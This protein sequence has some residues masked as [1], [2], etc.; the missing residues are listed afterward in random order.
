MSSISKALRAKV[1]KQ[2]KNQC[3]YCRCFQKYILT[4]LEIDHII[5]KASGGS[6]EEEN[7]WLACRSCNGYKGVQTDATDPVSK[8]KCNL[9]NPRMQDWTDHFV[10]RE[11][12]EIIEGITTVGRATVLALKLN[13]YYAVTVRRAWISAGWHPPN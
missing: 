13:N 10:W 12:G 5:P 3:G 2:A 1:R 7:L 9:F 11:N 8:R 4:A 6:D